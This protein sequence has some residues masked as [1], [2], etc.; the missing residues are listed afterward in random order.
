[1][2]IN[3]NAFYKHSYRLPTF[4][5]L[6]YAD[7]GN[8]NLKPEYAIQR[9]VG[10]QWVKDWEGPI[11]HTEVSLDTYHNTVRDKIIAYPKGR[12]F[13]WTMLNLG[14]VKIQGL[15]AAGT[16][17]IAPAASW[18]LYLKGQYT[19]QRAQDYTSPK[20]SYYG[21]QIP[22]IPRHSGT[23][24]VAVSYRG[25]SLNYS[26]IY[27]GERYH[28]QENTAYNYTQPWYT[29][30]VSLRAVYQAVGLRFSAT[31]EVCNLLNQPYEVVAN[32]PMPGRNYRIRI[33]VEM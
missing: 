29:S 20:D 31:L 26:F 21:H 17:M 13:Q 9:D 19:Y 25:Y 16:L 3:L 11:R 2:G 12:Q 7:L 10:I 18:G 32:Y 22:Y 8:A 5:D 4:N 30:D 6:Y 15:E 33:G 1:M 24:I 14:Y 27:T 28:Q 23:A